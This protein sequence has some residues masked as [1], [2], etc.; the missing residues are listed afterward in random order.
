MASDIFSALLLTHVKNF[1]GMLRFLMYRY[2]FQLNFHLSSE[3]FVAHDNQQRRTFVCP[4]HQQLKN[5]WFKGLTKV[6][7]LISDLDFL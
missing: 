3:S 6:V 1:L 5:T 4:K 2:G 7:S